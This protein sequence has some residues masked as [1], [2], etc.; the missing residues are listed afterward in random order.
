[1]QG[2]MD[3]NEA[4]GSGPLKRL[5]ASCVH[6][7]LLNFFCGCCCCCCCRC[8]ILMTC[9]GRPLDHTV[10]S[11]QGSVKE[12]LVRAARTTG[13]QTCAHSSPWC[14]DQFFF[15]RFWLGTSSGTSA[16]MN[17]RELTSSGSYR[18]YTRSFAIA[19]ESESV[20][21][22]QHRDS[23][24]EFSAQLRENTWQQG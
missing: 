23:K 7:R 3:S 5:C 18:Q 2:P 1:M 14:G 10:F 6:I 13:P 15:T 8:C 19:Q 4:T 17:C 22:L 9:F 20:L 11:S 12:P 24:W 21:R 16:V